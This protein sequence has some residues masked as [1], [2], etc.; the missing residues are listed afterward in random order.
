MGRRCSSAGCWSTVDGGDAD[1]HIVNRG[2]GILHNDIEI[3]VVVKDPGVDEFVLQGLPIPPPVFFD[4]LAVGKGGLGIFV[5]ILHV[6][7]GGRGVEVEVI[8]FDVLPMVAFVA[9]EAKQA[10]FENGIVAVPQ[11]QGKTQALMIIG[12]AGQAILAPAIGAGA[13]LVVGEIVPG[14]AIRAIVF[15]N[16]APLAL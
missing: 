10:L 3:A 16:G 11:G 13:G 2:L 14:S 7:V 9:G 5:E 15:P 8:L 1:Q 4:K 12:N 6:G